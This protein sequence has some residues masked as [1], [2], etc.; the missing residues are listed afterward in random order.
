MILFFQFLLCTITSTEN[1]KDKFKDISRS[2]DIFLENFIDEMRNTTLFE[3]DTVCNEFYR[4]LNSLVDEI[5][6]TI[7]L[8]TFQS[9]ELPDLRD[10]NILI[11]SLIIRLFNPLLSL[12]FQTFVHDYNEIFGIIEEIK[13]HF[14][15]NMAFER[16]QDDFD[17]FHIEN[18]SKNIIFKFSMYYYIKTVNQ[19]L[20]ERLKIL[21]H[22]YPVS[23]EE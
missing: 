11:E 3:N 19:T 17:V 7:S 14:N 18:A 21:P 13:T 16:I 6:L 10:Y 4:Y 12:N 9:H 2:H 8:I 22:I 5:N 15:E 20:K 1:T 23:L